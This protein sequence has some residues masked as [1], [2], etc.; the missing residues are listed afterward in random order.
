MNRLRSSSPGR[1]GRRAFTMLELMVALA[2][3]GLVV[4]GL[5]TFV[6]AM[7]ELWGRG[8]D[9]RLF[10]QHARAVTRTLTEELRQA[11]LP[12]SVES[13]TAAVAAQ[14]AVV[15][16]GRREDLV[17]FGL[18]EGSRLLPWPERPLP[19]VWC[20]LEV[21]RGEG[22]VLY[23]QSGW[24]EDFADEPPRK[25]VLTPL[26]TKLAYD[27]FDEDF[28]RWETEDRIRT[29]E[30]RALETPDRLRLTFTYRER[31]LE[32]VVPLPVFGKG[33]PPF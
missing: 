15:E 7:S 19:D 31:D 23:W 5:N 12:P 28:G 4:I 11:A 10:D 25:L 6:L 13:D 21:V 22:L 16:F 20:A 14:E 17:V 24:E 3:V 26:V 32:T 8:R 27:Y 9:W 18:R 1:C 33:L 30:D 29:G 2:L